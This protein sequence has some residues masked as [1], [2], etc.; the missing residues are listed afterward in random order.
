MAS[1][2]EPTQVTDN[3]IAQKYYQ[4][5]G[6]TYTETTRAYQ[7]QAA[8]IYQAQTTPIISEPEIDKPKRVEVEKSNDDFVSQKYYQSG[9][10]KVTETTRKT[11]N[12]D[13]DQYSAKKL[14]D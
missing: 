2:T 13:V 14:K 9:G 7:A 5:G 6:L 12:V 8:P 1:S 10:V 11:T 4:S 3:F